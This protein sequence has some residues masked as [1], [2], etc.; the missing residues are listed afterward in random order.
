[1]SFCR[2]ANGY[3]LG[4]RGGAYS[5]V[6]AG[7]EEHEFIAAFEAG[8]QLYSLTNAVAS[9]ETQIHEAQYD[10][11]HVKKRITQTEL[12]LLT[13]HMAAEERLQLLADLK[14][15]SERKGNIETALIALNRDHVRAQQELSD[16]RS[17][18]AYNGPYPNSATAPT[19]AN[20]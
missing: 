7:P 11:A 8:R 20:Y 5:G 14:D 16:Y 18:I 12:G 10:L 15:L 19:N 4:S 9:T 2:P 17:F 1:M 3:T 13:P 6:C